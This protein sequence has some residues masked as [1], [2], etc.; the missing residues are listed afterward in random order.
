[1]ILRKERHTLPEWDVKRG[2]Y[3]VKARPKMFGIGDASGRYHAADEYAAGLCPGGGLGFTGQ[4]GQCD[5]DKTKAMG[6][7]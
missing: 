3:H 1:M 5:T 7:F 4:S 6:I 2:K